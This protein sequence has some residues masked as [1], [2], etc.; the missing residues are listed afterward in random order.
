[1][2]WNWFNNELSRKEGVLH[3]ANMCVFGPLIS[4]PPSHPDTILTTVTYMQ[5]L[6]VDMGMEKVHLCMDMQLYEVTTQVCWNQ[7][8]KF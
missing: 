4:A 7:P 2:E 5:K 1:M 8:R 6:M 3:P